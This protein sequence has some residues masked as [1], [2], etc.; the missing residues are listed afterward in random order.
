[1][2]FVDQGKL[3][4]DDKVSRYIP[5]LTK[6]SKGYITIRDCL[7]HLTGIESEPIRSLKEQLN[8]KNIPILRKRLQILFLREKLFQTRVYNSVM[9]ILD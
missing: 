9:I 8:R 6:Y 4:L 2:T 3:S 1:M 5:V 7:A